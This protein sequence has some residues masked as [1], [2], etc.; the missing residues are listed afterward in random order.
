MTSSLQITSNQSWVMLCE[1]RTGCVCAALCG[2]GKAY[3]NWRNGEP[4]DTP[5]YGG[6]D[7][8]HIIG[9]GDDSF[10]WNDAN[11]NLLSLWDLPFH[12]LCQLHN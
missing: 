11:C 12:A 3:N 2:M 7:C 5:S 6:E 1:H 4:N 10:K 9:K 8:G